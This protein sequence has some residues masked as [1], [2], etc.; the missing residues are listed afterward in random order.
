MCKSARVSDGFPVAA[1]AVIV[2]VPAV[3]AGIIGLMSWLAGA[4]VL[5]AVS[6]VVALAVSV[7]LVRLLTRFAVP[8]WSRP[9]QAVRGRGAPAVR[10]RAVRAGRPRAVQSARPRAVQAPRRRAVQAAPPVRLVAART[11][12]GPRRAIEPVR[13]AGY[14][15]SA[16]SA[17]AESEPSEL[18][19]AL[20]R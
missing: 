6:G 14:P 15:A 18:V 19:P 20:R 11:V 17:L 8:G 3:G 9:V 2:G 12:P 7:G 5:L 10:R 1:V 4:V 16:L 13:T